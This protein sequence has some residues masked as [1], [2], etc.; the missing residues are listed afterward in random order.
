[1]TTDSAV[2]WGDGNSPTGEQGGEEECRGHVFQEVTQSRGMGCTHVGSVGPER[3]ELGIAECA[4][5]W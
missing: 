3:P 4:G 2:G 5:E 1:M